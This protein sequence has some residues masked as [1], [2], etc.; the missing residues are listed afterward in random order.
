M[1]SGEPTY[2]YWLT[3][4][5][6][7]NDLL[8]SLTVERNDK[9]NL[10][11]SETLER[12]LPQLVASLMIQKDMV[13]SMRGIFGQEYSQAMGVFLIYEQADDSESISPDT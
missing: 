1:G 6:L 13:E 10:E 4:T 2:G 8:S 3:C 11:P 7:V 9:R 5:D 12:V